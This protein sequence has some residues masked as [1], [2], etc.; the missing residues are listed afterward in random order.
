MLKKRVNKLLILIILS[1]LMFNFIGTNVVM[2]NYDFSA[3]PVFTIANNGGGG[4]SYDSSSSQ[5]K[6]PTGKDDGMKDIVEDSTGLDKEME[7]AGK[8]SWDNIGVALDGIVGI[9]TYFER[10]K[11]V[12]VGGVCQFLATVVGESAGSTESIT[13]LA[14]EDILFNKL[15]ITDINFFNINII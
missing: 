7:V 13:M 11:V 1:M 8:I 15:A 5:T 2:A 6:T 14:P 9:L 4:G 10:F 3:Q 12:I